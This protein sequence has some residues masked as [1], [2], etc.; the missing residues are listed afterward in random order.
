MTATR[1]NAR[2]PRRPATEA[3]PPRQFSLGS[4]LWFAV[5]SSLWCSQITLVRA[6]ALDNTHILAASSMAGVLI[7]WIVLS[8]F[9]YRQRICILFTF[10]YVCAGNDRA[11]VAF[12]LLLYATASSFRDLLGGSTLA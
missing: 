11:L 4:L 5:F 3:R 2:E 12:W 9:C 10:Q 6:I 1:S 8:W 7:A